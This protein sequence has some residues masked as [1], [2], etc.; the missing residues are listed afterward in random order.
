VQHVLRG[1]RLLQLGVGSGVK[2]AVIAWEALRD[3]PLN[4]HPAWAHLKGKRYEDADLPRSLMEEPQ[5]D[6]Y[7]AGKLSSKT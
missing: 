5:T 1:Q 2:G 7:L 4:S 3:V 6:A